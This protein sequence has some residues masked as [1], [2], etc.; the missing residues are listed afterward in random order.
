LARVGQAGVFSVGVE[1]LNRPRVAFHE[2]VER[3]LILFDQSIYIVYGGHLENTSIARRPFP[4]GSYDGH[5]TLFTGVRGATV[6]KIEL[7][8]EIGGSEG[9]RSGL[10]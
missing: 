10:V 9:G 8:P 5:S 1:V 7:G 6:W 3:Q 2:F 4:K